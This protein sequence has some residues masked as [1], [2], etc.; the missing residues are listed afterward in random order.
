MSGFDERYQALRTRFVERSRA[1]LP[2]LLAAAAEPAGDV[3]ALRM[4]VHR[5][6]GA[7]GTF[8]FPEISR[9]AGEVDDQLIET[10]SVDLDVLLALTRAVEGLTSGGQI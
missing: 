3:P 4:V 10:G 8:G 6:S 1:D 9:L 5:M 2:V 7:A